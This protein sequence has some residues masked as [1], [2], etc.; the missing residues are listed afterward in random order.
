MYNKI[1]KSL[2]DNEI[3]YTRDWTMKII[4]IIFKWV[5]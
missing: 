1:I 3:V 2:K 4:I 5:I